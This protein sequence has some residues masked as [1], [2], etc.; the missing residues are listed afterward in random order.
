MFAYFYDW[1]Q[2]ITFY[3]VLVTIVIQIIPDN[4]YQKYIRFFT[5]M[6][7][8]VMLAGPLIRAV[9]MGNRF[10]ELYQ[11][12]EY[13]QKRKE[14]EDTTKYLEGVSLEDVTEKNQADDTEKVQIEE[15][16]IENEDR[17]E[18]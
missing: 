17:L 11:S 10:S 7:L 1:L 8:I 12:A 3:L 16:Q 13:R 2:N 14:I 4:S 18:K 5:G 6:I 9:G 15:I